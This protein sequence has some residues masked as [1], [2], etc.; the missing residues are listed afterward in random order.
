LIEHLATCKNFKNLVAKRL[1]PSPSSV[2]W[3][4]QFRQVK[5]LDRFQASVGYN[6]SQNTSKTTAT[7][8]DLWSGYSNPKE[9]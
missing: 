6:R 1:S 7:L 3:G 8:L 4:E 2:G 5:I 9:N